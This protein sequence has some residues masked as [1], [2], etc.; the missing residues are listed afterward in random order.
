MSEKE[1]WEVSLVRCDICNHFWAAVRPEGTEK[2]ECPN[3]KNIC[4]FTNQTNQ[5]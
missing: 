4:N 3:C 2:L 1:K 5:Q